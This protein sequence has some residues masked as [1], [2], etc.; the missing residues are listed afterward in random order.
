MADSVDLNKPLEGVLYE[1]RNQIA[2]LTLN[3]PERGNALARSTRP[4]AL[5]TNDPARIPVFAECCADA[6]RGTGHHSRGD[7]P[8][9]HRVAL[10]ASEKPMSGAPTI[11]WS[12]NGRSRIDYTSGRFIA[13][14]ERRRTGTSAGER[15]VPSGATDISI[16]VRQRRQ[17]S[18]HRR[19]NR[20]ARLTALAA[21]DLR[22][23][24]GDI[25]LSE[26]HAVDVV[27]C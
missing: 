14:A 7:R 18:V 8:V 3:R 24:V 17:H 9:G 22:G 20:Q 11:Y 15:G 27:S 1:K 6:A 13:P 19:R 12:M 26:D 16:H 10:R 4:A 21:A 5:L 2:Y 23:V 25:D